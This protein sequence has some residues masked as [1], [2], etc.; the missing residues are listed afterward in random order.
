M[1]HV[2]RW[3]EDNQ[4]GWN[5]LDKRDKARALNELVYSLQAESTQLYK[6]HWAEIKKK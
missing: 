2:K 5:E 4:T 3:L 1:E 6:E